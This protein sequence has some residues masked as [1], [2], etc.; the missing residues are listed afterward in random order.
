MKD[1]ATNIDTFLAR[2]LVKDKK[3]RYLREKEHI[4]IGLDRNK[5]K[6]IVFIPPNKK[7]KVTK[8]GY[9]FP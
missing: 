1:N 8:R 7:P 2:T 4:F 3:I 6:S 9:L 5:N